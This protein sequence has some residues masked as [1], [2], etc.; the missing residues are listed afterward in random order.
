[1]SCC[2][3]SYITWLEVDDLLS[4]CERN[5]S[6]LYFLKNLLFTHI[7]FYWNCLLWLFFRRVVGTRWNLVL[8]YTFSFNIVCVIRL[9]LILIQLI[10]S[11]FIIYLALLFTALIE[12]LVVSILFALE[13]LAL[14]LVFRP[15][16]ITLLI[17]SKMLM[18]SYPL[19]N[20]I[21]NQTIFIV[22][23]YPKTTPHLPHRYLQHKLLFKVC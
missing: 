12:N 13:W 16:A 6:I 10:L 23:I 21:L 18:F 7:L 20:Y 8:S 14:L 17:T 11:F 3:T 5:Y 19:C 1:M 4:I 15:T 22:S 9:F 2:K